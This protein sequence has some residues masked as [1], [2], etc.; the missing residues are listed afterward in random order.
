MTGVGAATVSVLVFRR[1][2]YFVVNTSGRRVGGQEREGG[3]G[4]SV[5][6]FSS[7]L[8]LLAGVLEL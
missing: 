1:E 5:G 6:T 2:S 8:G 4:C 7:S 3:G